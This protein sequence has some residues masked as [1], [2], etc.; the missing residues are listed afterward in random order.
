MSRVLVTGAGGFIGRWTL[1][2]LK[3]QGFEVIEAGRAHGD[4]LSPGAPAALIA[5]TK[6]THLLHLAWTTAHGLFWQDPANDAWRDATLDLLRAFAEAGGTR[7]VV[8]GSCAELILGDDGAPHTLYGRT[9]KQVADEGAAILAAAGASHAHA[10]L[11][12]SYGPHE[13]PD[14]LVPAI[15]RALLRGERAALTQGTQVRDFLHARDV[16]GALAH[17]VTADTTG[18]L[19]LGSGEPLTIAAVARTIGRLMDRPDLIGLGDLPLRAGDPPHLGADATALHAS[20]FRPALT[21]E[22]GL[23]DV[24][25]WWRAQA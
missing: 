13:H 25:A 24:I 11:F 3:A 19:D 5:A 9:K 20:G 23:A 16:A 21:L 8:A 14:R 4:L 18:S 6:P 22:A 15:V 2:P 12:F 7:A 1:A 10:R 17:L